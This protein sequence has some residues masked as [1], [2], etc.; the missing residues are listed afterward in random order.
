MI[1]TQQSPMTSEP[2]L[3]R[4]QGQEK[5]EEVVPFIILVFE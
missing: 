1:W 4:E 3:M 2:E 5:S